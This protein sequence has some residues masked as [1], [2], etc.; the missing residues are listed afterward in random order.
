VKTVIKWKQDVYVEVSVATELNQRLKTVKGDDA[1]DR[2]TGPQPMAVLRPLI[3]AGEVR[4]LTGAVKFERTGETWTGKEV[5]LSPPE[6]LAAKPRESWTG[7]YVYLEGSPEAETE[8]QRFIELEKPV[9]RETPG[10][11]HDAMRKAR[12]ELD[13]F[14]ARSKQQAPPK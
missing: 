11:R 8:L 13:A 1:G 6:L 2:F 14:R 10:R 3:K 4:E 5:T 12:A 7:P 9:L